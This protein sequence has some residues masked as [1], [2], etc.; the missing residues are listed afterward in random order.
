[1]ARPSV[2]TG[3]VCVAATLALAGPAGAQP[4]RATLV[5][6][7]EINHTT[8]DDSLVRRRLLSSFPLGSPEAALPPYLKQ[9]G[10]KI[11]RVT[12]V[13]ATGD[14]V[15]GRATLRWGHPSAV[16]KSASFGARPRMEHSPR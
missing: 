8:Q 13:G 6:G 12:N 2:L 3:L 11:W 5:Q 1:M 9:Q 7:A 10:F 4:R 15:Y 14:Q 16:A